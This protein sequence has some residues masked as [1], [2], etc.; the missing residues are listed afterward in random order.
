MATATTRIGHDIFRGFRFDDINFATEEHDVNIHENINSLLNTHRGRIFSDVIVKGTVEVLSTGTDT[1]VSAHACALFVMSDENLRFFVFLSFCA[2]KLFRCK[3][4]RDLF[5][6]RDEHRPTSP[7]T[8]RGEYGGRSVQSQ[9]DGATVAN[10]R[11]TSVHLLLSLSD[12]DNCSVLSFQLLN[13]RWRVEHWNF[14][15]FEFYSRFLMADI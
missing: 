5:Y 2:E 4:Y 15:N 10:G 7:V 9:S 6:L 1:S 8:F 14:K 3:E 13:K 12:C 11:T